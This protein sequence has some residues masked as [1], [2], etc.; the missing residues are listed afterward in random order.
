MF[1][2]GYW[3]SKRYWYIW[4]LNVTMVFEFLIFIRIEFNNFAPDTETAFVPLL[5]F[6]NLCVHQSR[7]YSYYCACSQ[8]ECDCTFL[9]AL[10]C[11]I[12]LWFRFL[13]IMI[14]C[15]ASWFNIELVWLILCLR[16]RREAVDEFYCMVIKF[17]HCLP[18]E[19]KA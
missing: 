2:C 19:T 6:D 18:A 17:I 16:F 9:I 15:S 3:C 1:P 7:L 14:Y 4:L 10:L 12:N 5:F 11:L 13:H 8:F